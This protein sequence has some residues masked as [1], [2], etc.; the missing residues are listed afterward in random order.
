MLSACGSWSQGL[1]TNKGKKQRH[2]V[3]RSPGQWENYN[4]FQG[5]VCQIS[6]Q[7]VTFPMWCVC[8]CRPFFIRVCLWWGT[9]LCTSLQSVPLFHIYYVK[10]TWMTNI[11]MLH[12][13]GDPSRSFFNLPVLSL[14]LVFCLILTIISNK[15][16]KKPKEIS[17]GQF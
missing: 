1:D 16:M 3:C 9:Q 8:H 13:L 15:G 14:L 11:D 5:T 7:Q 17:F 6:I 4:M 10:C 12:A 2:H